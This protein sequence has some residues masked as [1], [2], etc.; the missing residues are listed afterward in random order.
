MS[1][2]S[3]DT[4]FPDVP[5]YDLSDSYSRFV[6]FTSNSQYPMHRWFRY[7]EGYSRDLVHLL[8]AERESNTITCLD[9]FGGSG[10]T[11][12]ACSEIGLSCISIEVNPFVYSVAKS[13][14]NTDYSKVALDDAVSRWLDAFRLEGFEEADIPAMK[15]I[16]ESGGRA[17]WLYHDETLKTLLRLRKSLK[18]VD[19]PYKNLFE[20]TLASVSLDVGN[21]KKDGKCVRYK[22]HWQELH[23]T[24]QAVLDRL[25]AS[26]KEIGKDIGRMEGKFQGRPKNGER[27]LLGSALD[28]L[29]SLKSDS[30]DAV[31]TS[32]PYLNTFDYTDVYMPEL[33]LF[34]H[35]TSYGE[36]RELRKRTIRSH[37]QIP[38]DAKNP[39]LSDSI[40]DLIESISGDG[41]SWNKSIPA[42]LAGYCHDMKQV[43]RE[44]ARIVRTGG[45]VFVVVGTSSYNHVHVPTDVILALI[46]K[47][48]G[49][50]LKEVRISRT[51]R[52]SSKQ[53][54]KLSAQLPP[55]RESILH[56]VRD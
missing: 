56:L 43:F 53:Q 5:V 1:E 2:I 36:V 23:V 48:S 49:F 46:A 16:S 34:G 26:I 6:S 25:L 33:W 54:G 13:K 10:T 50:S 7:K 35:V 44:L 9:P 20:T 14:L 17:K 4:G 55:L 37:V 38:W 40:V 42:M 12:L 51:F 28:V 3:F 32:P 8:L 24:E 18:A 30:V 15:T 21:T 31:V 11:A 41:E 19:E 45:N 52:R 27:L 22:P 39:G 47:D 29:P